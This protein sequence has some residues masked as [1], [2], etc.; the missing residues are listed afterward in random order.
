MASHHDPRIRRSP[1][2]I[3][4]RYAIRHRG[5]KRRNQSSSSP[6]LI[7]GPFSHWE[8]SVSGPRVRNRNQMERDSKPRD[9]LA[10]Q[11]ILLMTCRSCD[12]RTLQNTWNRPL[13]LASP[14]STQLP[15][16]YS[17]ITPT[18]HRTQ[19]RLLDYANEKSV[20]TG[21]KQS[22]LAR[23]QVLFSVRLT[24]LTVRKQ[25]RILHYHKIW[26]GGCTRIY[27]NKL[28]QGTLLPC[29]IG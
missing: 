26:Y 18:G 5:P 1:L 24:G 7:L 9:S 23:S 14:I 2:L 10:V 28:G 6:H 11:V 4:P 8:S 22:G 19:P 12:P 25:V 20:G 17:P 16:T 21:L 3:I 13:R 29:N 15:V 27:R